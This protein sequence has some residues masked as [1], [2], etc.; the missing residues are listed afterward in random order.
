MISKDG[1]DLQ[2][3]G[4]LEGSQP[5]LSTPAWVLASLLGSQAKPLPSSYTEPKLRPLHLPHK[6]LFPCT[7][8][9]SL[10]P[11]L[12]KT[13]PPQPNVALPNRLQTPALNASTQTT[14]RQ[15]HSSTHQKSEMT[16]TQVTDERTR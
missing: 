3:V 16:K 12:S 4:E 13:L 1:G 5:A 14:P 6:D 8:A 11:T 10:G 15:E 7:G 9:L 2:G